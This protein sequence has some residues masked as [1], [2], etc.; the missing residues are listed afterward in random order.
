MPSYICSFQQISTRNRFTWD[1]RLTIIMYL[2]TFSIHLN[3]RHV[4]FDRTIYIGVSLIQ[5]CNTL[6]MNIYHFL[7]V[8]MMTTFRGN[9][10]I[11]KEKQSFWRM[12]RNRLYKWDGSLLRLIEGGFKTRFL[13]VKALFLVFDTDRGS[14]TLHVTDFIAAK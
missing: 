10:H 5:G 8:I 11:R 9:D 12:R 13:L 6:K 2:D 1:V 14:F 7:Q 4:K 3:V